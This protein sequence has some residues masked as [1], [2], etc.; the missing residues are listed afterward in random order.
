M[1]SLR[2]KQAAIWIVS[3]AVA[4]VITVALVYGPLATDIDTYS[5]KYFVLTVIPLGCFFVIWGDYL[6]GAQILPD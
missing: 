3:M 4:L 1:D 5:I 2:V 6:L